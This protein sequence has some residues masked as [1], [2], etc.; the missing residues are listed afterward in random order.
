MTKKSSEIEETAAEV[1]E[2]ND[3][4]DQ[5]VE[6]PGTGEKIHIP[7]EK[8][9]TELKDTDGQVIPDRILTALHNEHVNYP[10]EINGY[11]K[12]GDLQ[13]Q[14]DV[15]TTL[16]N[17]GGKIDPQSE[18]LVVEVQQY[19]NDKG[20]TM[21]IKKSVQKK[22]YPTIQKLREMAQAAAQPPTQ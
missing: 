6:V 1:E 18:Q 16:P 15:K 9:T 3:H 7:S 19:E 4:D 11:R 13:I 14:Q 17:S 2:V 22:Y 8:A 20:E 10:E 12:A 5:V 21:K